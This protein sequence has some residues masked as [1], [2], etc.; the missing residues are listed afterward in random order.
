MSKSITHCNGKLFDL[1]LEFCLTF[2][3]H[4]IELGL[5]NERRFVYNI[6]CMF[7][8]VLY[9]SSTF[10]VFFTHLHDAVLVGYTDKLLPSP[11]CL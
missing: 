11:P 4:K 5:L 10:R 3:L 6:L 9:S 2:R 7:D 1:C 8:L